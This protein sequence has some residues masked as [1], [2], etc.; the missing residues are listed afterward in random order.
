MLRMF[1]DNRVLLALFLVVS[2]IGLGLTMVSYSF[3]PVK[4]DF[5]DFQ[6]A[7]AQPSQEVD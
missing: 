5:P 1:E 7:A 3:Q 2:L 4:A 6:L